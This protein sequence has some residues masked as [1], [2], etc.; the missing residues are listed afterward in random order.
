MAYRP[1]PPPTPL[2]FG[3]DPV[4]DLPPDH[5]ARLVEQVVEQTVQPPRRDP[6][7]GQPPY[8]PRL[9]VKVLVYGYATGI[10]SSRQLERHCRESLPYL[11]LTRGDTPSYH[12]LCTARTEEGAYLEAVWEGLFAVAAAVG[13]PRLG[14][15]VVDSTK[16]RADASPEAVVKP[17]EYAALQAE[18]QRILTEAAAADA[19]EAAAG[20]PGTTT[21][22]QVVPHEQMR[23]IL[24][25]VRKQREP[26]RA[27]DPEHADDPDGPSDPAGPGAGGAAAPPRVLPLEDAPAPSDP[28]PAAAAPVKPMSPKMLLRIRAGLQALQAAAAANRKHLCLT[29]PDA[30][31]MS[32]GRAR[33]VRECHAW[34]VAIDNGL[35]VAGQTT[36]SNVDAP[37]LTPLL[38]AAQ[39]HEPEGIHSVDADS[40][41]YSGDAVAALI[42]AGIDVCIPDPHTAADLH[43][44][45]PIGTTRA[46]ARGQIEF[47]YDPQHDVYRCPEGNTL[48]VKGRRQIKGQR[49]TLYRATAPCGACPQ[50]AACLTHPAAQHRTLA[51]GQH[52]AVLAAARVR[53]AEPEHQERYHHR[54]EAV[55]TVFGF[56]RAA[57]GYTRWMLRTQAKVAMEGQW[58][59]TAYQFRK[60]HL[61]WAG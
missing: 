9:C 38:A 16:I 23:D 45:R 32:E 22:G 55:E 40:G 54:G 2:L 50:A 43:R 11:Y 13:L 5:L 34:E 41:F 47:E 30:R 7:C 4:R 51:V 28:P 46:R 21:L 60:V 12:T 39:Q 18:L 49:L 1:Y 31:M 56:V 29:D 58:I 10:R 53:F 35:L 27:Q 33:Q 19:R 48:A 44:G 37:R 57:L 6:Q 36:Q 15:V 42:L 25:R 3:Y 61:A 52:A 26:A 20:E 14:R 17:E 8:D 59:K 24:R